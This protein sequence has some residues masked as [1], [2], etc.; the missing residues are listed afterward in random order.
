VTASDFPFPKITTRYLDVSVLGQLAA[1]NLPLGDEFEPS[2]V[3]VIGFEAAFRR[4]GFGK[5]DLENA[6]ETRT[7]PSYSPTPMPNSTVLRSGFIWCSG[8]PTEDI[9]TGPKID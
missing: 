8:R 9:N 1:T 5:Q 6:P 2:P 7:T 4:R 3:K